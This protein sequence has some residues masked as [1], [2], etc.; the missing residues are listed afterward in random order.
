MKKILKIQGQGL[1]NP[2]EKD[3]K[4]VQWLDKCPELCDI[5]RQFVRDWKSAVILA[6]AC[7][8]WLCVAPSWYDWLEDSGLGDCLVQ[9]C[10]FLNER[11]FVNLPVCI[12]LVWLS[13]RWGY[14]IWK[15]E[16]VRLYR[17]LI[18][19]LGF[20]LLH[21]CHPSFVSIAGDFTYKCFLTILLC[22]LSIV[23]I[24]KLFG[25]PRSFRKRNSKKG[26]SEDCS[27]DKKTKIEG[28]TLDYDK[29]ANTSDSLDKY[30]DAIVHRLLNTNLDENAYAM[31]ITSKWGSGK[32]TF[33]DLLKAKFK[34]ETEI[35]DFNP[36]NC[37]T[38]EQVIEDFFA[39][40]RDNLSPK[41]SSLSRPIREYAKLIGSVS[42]PSIQGI[43]FEIQPFSD[44][45]SISKKKKE[46]SE[47]LMLLHKRVVVFIDDLDRL[48]GSEVFEVLRLVRNTANISNVIYVVAYDREYV[49]NI[50]IEKGICNVSDYL[51]KIFPVEVPLPKVE[52]VQ[53][54][55]VFQNDLTIQS[56]FNYNFAK[57]FTGHF[58]DSDQNLILKVLDN[59]RRVKHFVRLYMLDMVY[60]YGINAYPKE[61]KLLDLFWLELLQIYDKTVYDIL[62]E[63]PLF[64]LSCV[65]NR[66]YLRQG[67]CSGLTYKKDVAKFEGS[68][69]GKSLTPYLLM[70]LFT[71][72]EPIHPLSICYVENFDKFFTLSVSPLKLSVSEY[73]QLLNCSHYPEDIVNKWI[74]EEKSLSSILFMSSKWGINFMTEQ[75]LENY[76]H[77]MLCLCCS[78]LD[79]VDRAYGVRN[80]FVTNRY[81]GNQEQLAADFVKDWFYN[82]I[83]RGVGL[84]ETSRLLN[85][86]FPTAEVVDDDPRY[87]PLRPPKIVVDD[88]IELLLSRVIESC[89]VNSTEPTAVSVFDTSCLIGKVFANCCVKTMSEIVYAVDDEAEID[90]YK[91][92]AWNTVIDCFSALE[93]KPSIDDYYSAFE[94]FLHS[95]NSYSTTHKDEILSGEITDPFDIECLKASFGNDYKTKLEM[96]KNKCFVQNDSANNQPTDNN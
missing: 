12:V 60:L 4:I 27:S 90:T 9:C 16:D 80:V 45:Q 53:L 71:S 67:I 40:L 61:H 62:A 93:Q 6:L 69:P 85:R 28:F 76:L 5:F 26:T 75:Q 50:L 10:S 56:F 24:L 89:L 7:I 21:R 29:Q 66:F 15:D 81:A 32:T 44:N 82:R 33:L 39:T 17:L 48:E 68:F 20:L 1:I 19:V 87:E 77:G 51:K 88:A 35:I 94:R 34:D 64:L 96:F 46:L 65:G 91:Q 84:V 2:N 14:R 52:N 47:K 18:I 59:Y 31:G 58:D 86:L 70:R 63:N 49:T 42:V 8:I 83:D 92:M 38:P 79:E 37:R 13:C 54:W 11:W 41:H 55:E 78:K 36:W 57:E 95:K 22:L 73:M 25:L 30:A 3:S 23:M 74:K 72:K 43:S